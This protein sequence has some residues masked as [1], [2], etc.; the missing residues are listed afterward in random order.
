MSSYYTALKKNNKW[1]KKINFEI[2][3]GCTVVNAW[4]LF[5]KYFAVRNK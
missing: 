5:N 1:Y 4:I 2:I 3:T